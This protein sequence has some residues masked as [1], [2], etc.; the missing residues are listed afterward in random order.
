MFNNSNASSRPNPPLLINLWSSPR[1]I[2]TALMYSFAQRSD[3]AVFDEPL[4]AHYLTKTDSNAYHPGTKEILQSQDNDGEQVVNNILLTE[5]KK[6][7]VFFKQMTH[8]L[9]HLNRDFLFKMHNVLL[10]RDPRRII[11]SYA[12]VVSNP[13]IQDVGI[14]MQYELFLELSKADKLTAIIDTKQLLLN[15]E[16]I[17]KL[18]CDKLNIPFEKQ[19]LSWP[20][21]ARPEDGVWAKYWY[22]NVHQ[23]SEFLKYEEK[24]VELSPQLEKLAESCMPFYEKLL[25]FVL[26]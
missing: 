18:L 10:I 21:S 25:G 7:V 12:K 17:L 15:P 20:K 11:A 22:K 9:I 1:N 24:V 5:H 26:K 16:K 13:T 2:S 4:Y 8:H 6:S 14:E 23:S 19:M 3:S